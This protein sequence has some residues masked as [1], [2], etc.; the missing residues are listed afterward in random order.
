MLFVVDGP[1]F[2]GKWISIKLDKNLF[3]DFSACLMRVPTDVID[4]TT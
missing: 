2:Y 4:D 1:I 3:F